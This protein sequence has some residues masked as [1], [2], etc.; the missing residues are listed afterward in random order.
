MERGYEPFLP[1][2]YRAPT[3]LAFTVGSPE[4][5]RKLFAAAE[6]ADLYLGRGYG[7]H[8]ETTFRVANFPAL[9]DEAY[10]AL[11]EVMAKV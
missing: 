9:P 6:A 2:A 4:R 8:Q 10:E 11:L 1:A 3:V 7:P 5:L